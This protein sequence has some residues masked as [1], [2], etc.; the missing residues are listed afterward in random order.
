MTYIKYKFD[1]SENEKEGIPLEKEVQ[2]RGG[3]LLN[4]VFGPHDWV[5]AYLPSEIDL[6]GLEA[7]Q[8]SEITQEEALAIASSHS[9]LY[10]LD[11]DGGIKY[12]L[13]PFLGG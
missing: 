5:V 9:N 13:P 8:V 11:D 6:D 3:V 7:W 2:S 1:F 4:T 12:T 10:Y